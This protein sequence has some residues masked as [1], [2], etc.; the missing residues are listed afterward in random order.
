MRVTAR[1]PAGTVDDMGDLIYSLI[2]LAMIVAGAGVIIYVL[3]NRLAA[4]D[5]PS[6]RAS[7]MGRAH[8]V[9]RGNHSNMGPV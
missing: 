4:P 5:L 7:E 1:G 2:M 9:E 3:R 6:E 8:G